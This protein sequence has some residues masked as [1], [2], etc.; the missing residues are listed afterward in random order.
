L[1]LVMGS[2]TTPS[3]TVIVLSL[4][5]RGLLTYAKPV[6]GASTGSFTEGTTSESNYLRIDP[7]I[8]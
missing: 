8:Q 7:R 4:L 2:I 1:I 6:A 5:L 3:L